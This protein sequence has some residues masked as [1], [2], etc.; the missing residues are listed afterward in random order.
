MI[1]KKKILID[2]KQ[3]NKKVIVEKVERTV[4]PTLEFES[5]SAMGDGLYLSDT[6][7]RESLISVRLRI[8]SRDVREKIKI[9]D[10][11]MQALNKRGYIKLE[12]RGEF[13]QTRYDICKLKSSGKEEYTRYYGLMELEFINPFGV[14]FGLEKEL[15]Y[16]STRGIQYLCTSEIYPQIILSPS[17]TDFTLENKSAGSKIHM[18]TS[19]KIDKVMIDLD[20]KF[21]YIYTSDEQIEKESLMRFLTLDSDFFNIKNHDEL[22]LTN[23]TIQKAT[24]VERWL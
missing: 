17:S 6:R 2:D 22:K 21:I 3:L 8:M 1:L 24:Y 5:Y 11:I 15:T 20:K 14:M 4:L 9:R 23:C 16:S 13:P 7:K 18:I 10:E 12:I 19:N